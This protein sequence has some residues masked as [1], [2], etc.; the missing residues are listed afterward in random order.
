MDT[1][2]GVKGESLLLTF[3]W[4]QA[5]FMLAYKIEN[6][7]SDSVNS[8]FH[9][10]KGLLGYEKFHELFPIILTDNGSEFSKPDE[11]EFNVKPY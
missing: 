3:L 6:K 11:I 9:Y 7:E 2:E 10:L 8:F 4:R 1:V 5:N